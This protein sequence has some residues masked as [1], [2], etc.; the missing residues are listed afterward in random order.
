MENILVVFMLAGSVG[1]IVLGQRLRERRLRASQ[2]RR[3]TA[4]RIVSPARA[5]EPD[6]PRA[7]MPARRTVSGNSEDWLRLLLDALHLLI[8]GHSRG[9][10]TTLIHE[11]ATRL[12]KHGTRVVVCDL[13]A[14]PGLWAGCEVYGYKND[15]AAINDALASIRAEVEQRRTRRGEGIQRTFKPLYLIIDEYQDVGRSPLCPEARPLVED[16]LRRGGKLNL[17]LLIGVQDKQVRTMGFEGQGELRRNFTY[18][19][20]VR[21][22]RHLMRWATLIDPNEEENTQTYLIPALPDLDKLVEAAMDAAPAP[23]GEYIPRVQPSEASVTTAQNGAAGSQL[24]FS[25]EE[26]ARIVALILQGKDEAE[27]VAAM[28]R[29]ARRRHKA[30]TAFYTRLALAV[31]PGMEHRET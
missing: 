24:D 13:D 25:A 23:R 9:G 1:L 26:I 28:P 19:V 15:I 10:K 12:A 5:V 11:L 7:S 30:Y 22:D 3:P 21:R 16:I 6:P 31:T 8:I 29:Y 18:V 27:I 2:S 17:H 4:V 20:E 14:A